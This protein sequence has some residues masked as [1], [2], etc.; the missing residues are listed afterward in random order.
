LAKTIEGDPEVDKV[1]AL[2]KIRR[3]ARG[4]GRFS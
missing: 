1:K 2:K 3:Y 4:V